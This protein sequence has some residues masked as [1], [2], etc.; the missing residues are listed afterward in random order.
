MSCGKGLF[1]L[2]DFENYLKFLK[3]SNFLTFKLWMF[4]KCA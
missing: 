4:L 3:I 2:Y 1:K